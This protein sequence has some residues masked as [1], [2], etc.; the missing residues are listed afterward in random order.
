MP[1]II[2]LL[3]LVLWFVSDIIEENKPKAP[4]VKDWNKYN[5]EA[6]GMSARDIKK[7]L[8]SGRW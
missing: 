4:G 5:R 1:F 8:K 3:F 2:V 7:G 6:V